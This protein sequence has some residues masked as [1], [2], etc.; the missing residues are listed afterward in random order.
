MTGGSRVFG[1]NDVLIYKL[2][3]NAGSAYT[4][5]LDMEGEYLVTA[6]TDKNTY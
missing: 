5:T 3:G 4:I 2:E 1:Q 6:S